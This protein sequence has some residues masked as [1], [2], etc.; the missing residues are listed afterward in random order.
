MTH[1]SN[2]L[3]RALNDVYPSMK[4]DEK[5][6]VKPS[7]RIF[8]LLLLMYV[9]FCTTEFF[10]AA[11][12]NRRMFFDELAKNRGSDPLLPSTWY[13]FAR[14]ELIKTKVILIFNISSIIWH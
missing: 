6:G 3:I 14:K 4:L 10:W 11:A 1:Y 12:E 2:S 7:M 5:F 13:N 9:N 8:Y